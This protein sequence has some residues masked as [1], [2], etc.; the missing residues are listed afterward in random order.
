MGFHN[1]QLMHNGLFHFFRPLH[2]KG[3]IAIA[4]CLIVALFFFLFLLKYFGCFIMYVVYLQWKKLHSWN[5][6]T[7]NAFLRQ[8][9]WAEF[10]L[11]HN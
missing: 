10:C 11:S 9:F 6:T 1:E 7:E 4:A 5:R 8:N 2:F 3:C